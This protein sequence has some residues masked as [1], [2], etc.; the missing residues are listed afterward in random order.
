MFSSFEASI[1]AEIAPL[2]K[3]INLL[4]INAPPV[5]TGVQ[6]GERNV[7]I[8]MG[9]IVGM[10]SSKSKDGSDMK[11]VG[12]VMSTQISTLMPKTSFSTISTTITTRPVTKGGV[13]GG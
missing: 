6:R 3:L 4:S 10:G 9:S 12:K 2:L 7:T 13:I 8:G 1:K 11:V 5:R